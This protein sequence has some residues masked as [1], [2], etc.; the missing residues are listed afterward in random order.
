MPFLK[1]TINFCLNLHIKLLTLH[2]P[3]FSQTNQNLYQY[4]VK[5]TCDTQLLFLECKQKALYMPLKEDDSLAFSQ[6]LTNSYCI[7]LKL[8]YSEGISPFL[9]KSVH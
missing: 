1:K 8:L 9:H 4:S 2:T 3:C 6:G 7:L 5:H